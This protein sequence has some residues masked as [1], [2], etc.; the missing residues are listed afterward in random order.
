MFFKDFNFTFYSNQKKSE[1]WKL[2][3]NDDIIQFNGEGTLLYMTN[4]N[5]INDSIQ[6]QLK[7]SKYQH[8]GK[9]LKDGVE[10]DSYLK[11][12]QTLFFSTL[13]HPETNQKFYSFTFLN[14]KK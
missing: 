9:S 13:I 8:T 12:N 7:E 2:K 11:E 3:G 14:S 5:E 4:N 6:K 1:Q 10:V